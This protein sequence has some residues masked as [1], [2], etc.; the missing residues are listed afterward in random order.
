M[1]PTTE[2]SNAVNFDFV[3]LSFGKDKEKGLKVV[4]GASKSSIFDDKIE[5]RT[6]ESDLRE[7][8]TLETLNGKIIQFKK[9][10]F[11]TVKDNN[12]QNVNGK[13]IEIR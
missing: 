1:K 10:S 6:E 9:G 13:D 2:G 12:R 3:C 11:K 4:E 8:D 5:I 7:N